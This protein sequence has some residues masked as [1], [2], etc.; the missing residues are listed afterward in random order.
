MRPPYL[1]LIKYVPVAL[2]QANIKSQ[3][4]KYRFAMK[5]LNNLGFSISAEGVLPDNT[6]VPAMAAMRPSSTKKNSVRRFI[7]MISNYHIFIKGIVN[8]AS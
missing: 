1:L 7:G 5:W 2:N 6:K 3:P 4:K 8:D